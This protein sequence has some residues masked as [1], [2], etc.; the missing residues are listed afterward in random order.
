[1]LV[2]PRVDSR[3][4][5]AEI[6]AQVREILAAGEAL[7]PVDAE[8]LRSLEPDLIHYPGFVPRLR[9]GAGRSG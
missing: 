7:Y 8:L 6:D 2:R 4:A 5:A 1:M 3:V 9:G